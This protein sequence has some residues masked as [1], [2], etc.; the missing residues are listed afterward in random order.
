[1]NSVDLENLKR[2]LLDLATKGSTKP[3][4]AAGLRVLTKLIRPTYVPIIE[5]CELR[6]LD[7]SRSMIFGVPWTSEEYPWPLYNDYPAGP[8]VQ[9]DLD[10]VS[11]AIG[12]TIGSGFLQ[13]FLPDDYLAAYGRD[14]NG[15]DAIMRVIPKSTVESCVEPTPPPWAGKSPL[16][17][18]RGLGFKGVPNSY[19][20]LEPDRGYYF[21]DDEPW[22][23]SR[24][25]DALFDC[26]FLSDGHK[27]SPADLITGWKRANVKAHVDLAA[28]SD[29]EIT[30]EFR[31]WK[32]S[33]DEWG[34]N[35][36]AI[37]SIL[38]PSHFI[39]NFPIPSLFGWPLSGDAQRRVVTEESMPLFVFEGSNKEWGD[40]IEV[41][42][43]EAYW[44][45]GYYI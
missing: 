19:Q 11:A 31:E 9:L 35:W 2:R 6:S 33:P 5:K 37:C 40:W 20:D 27:M 13:V 43:D 30:S 41:F 15:I 17:F 18:C 8:L 38:G 7:R 28:M 25:Q 34:E 10:D 22:D 26:G 4:A 42:E 21:D 3:N 39:K 45:F 29:N 14:G 32:L 16:E 24:L 36:E 23:I 1:M 12:E 44:C